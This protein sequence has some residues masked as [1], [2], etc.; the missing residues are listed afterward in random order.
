VALV[1][2]VV[3]WLLLLQAPRASTLPETAINSLVFIVSLLAAGTSPHNVQEPNCVP[4]TARGGASAGGF[5]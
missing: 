1:A 3:T 2:L 5:R 4:A